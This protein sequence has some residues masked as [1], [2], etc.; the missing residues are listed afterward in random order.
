MIKRICSLLIAAITI[1]LTAPAHAQNPPSRL[2]FD[3]ASIKL[4]NDET[5]NGMIKA[6]PGGHGYTAHNINVRTMIS[7]MYKIPARQIKGG[8][9][10]LDSDRYDVEARA[11]KPYN[12]D[13]LHTMYQNLL[14]DRF[15]LKF[16]KET[17]EGPVYALT[18]DTPGSKMKVDDSPQDFKI[19]ITFSADG[20]AVGVRVPISYLAWWLG[21]QLQNDARPV[22]DMTGLDKNYDFT[23]TFMPVLPP[24]VQKETLPT[25]LQNRPSIFEAVKQQLGLKLTAQKGPVEYYVIDHIDRPSD[26]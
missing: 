6:T 12:L 24:D 9:D 15:N 21:Q 26:N 7:L 19:P 4:A 14:T 13:D 10:W 11:D 16:H 8:P 25:E 23:L 20:S 17:K 3:V 1:L 18:L 22:V 2:T 5:R